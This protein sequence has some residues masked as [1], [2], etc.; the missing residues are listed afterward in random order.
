LIAAIELSSFFDA[1]Y[2]VK[3]DARHMA[4]GYPIIEKNYAMSGIV[5]D[6]MSGVKKLPYFIPALNDPTSAKEPSIIHLSLRPTHN[7]L[8][9]TQRPV[10]TF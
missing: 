4:S 8:S 3:N 1:R 2:G 5:F 9:T 10:P 6:A 7:R